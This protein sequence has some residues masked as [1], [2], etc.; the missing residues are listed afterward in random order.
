MSERLKTL[1]D[2]D[3][4]RAQRE[5]TDEAARRRHGSADAEMRRK[6]G[7]MTPNEFEAWKRE[8]GG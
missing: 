5:L 1:S 4:A 3:L 8:I 2:E 6:V 7:Q